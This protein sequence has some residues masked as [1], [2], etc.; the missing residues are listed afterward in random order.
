MA[1]KGG[2]CSCRSRSPSPS[3]EF[4]GQVY[5]FLMLFPNINW[6]SVRKDVQGDFVW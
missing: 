1:S 4:K 3:H 6:F 5:P 2:A